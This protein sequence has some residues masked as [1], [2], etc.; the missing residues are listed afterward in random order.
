MLED[1]T[2]ENDKNNVF[3]DSIEDL[4][5]E[6]SPEEQTEAEFYLL[7]YLDVVRRI[8]ERVCREHPELLTEIEKP[9]SLKL[10]KPQNSF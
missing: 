2:S 5:P 3:N 7:G 9:A 10:E 4:Y 6:L 1:I 8:Y